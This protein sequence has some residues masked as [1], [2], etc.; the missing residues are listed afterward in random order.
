[1]KLNFLLG[2]LLITSCAK[3]EEIFKIYDVKNIYSSHPNK[4]VEF[5]AYNPDQSG[6]KK[7][8]SCAFK[9]GTET[10]AVV[11]IV[12]FKEKEVVFK[13]KRFFYCEI[14]KIDELKLLK[15]LEDRKKAELSYKKQIEREK[16][17][18]DKVNKLLLESLKESQESS[19]ELIKFIKKI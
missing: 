18:E 3:N 6:I 10:A 9:K 11:S 13:S 8:V 7:K 19:D 1:M 12:L 17:M 5:W 14:V 2:L 16:K 15:V 4:L